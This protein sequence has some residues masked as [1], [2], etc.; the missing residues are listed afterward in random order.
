M[1][2]ISETQTQAQSQAH[3][4]TAPEAPSKVAFLATARRA[5]VK[6]PASERIKD[7]L[8]F[9]KA[10]DDD[11]IR[12]QAT[13][14]MDCGVP[15]CGSACPLGNPLPQIHSLVVGGHFK[16]AS[17]LLHQTNNFP[18][19][20]GRLCPALCE[21]SCS[22]GLIT[23]PMTNR[24]IELAVVE[25]AF[26]SG[27]V[28]PQIATMQS[29]YSVG[30]VGSGPSGLACAQQLA[31]QGHKVTVYERAKVIGGLLAEGI[32]N[33]KLDKR[34]LE[35]R[36]DQLVAEGVVFKPG[37]D[38]NN[39]NSLATIYKH[40]DA[41]CLTTGATVPRDLS[42]PGRQMLGTH[43]A[44][45]FLVQQNRLLAGEKISEAALITA[46]DKVVV[47]LGGGDTGADCLGV[48]LRQGARS[49]IQVEM[50]PEPP[51]ERDPA[52]PWPDWPNI[53]R[54]NSAHEEGGQR[55]F[56][57]GTQS[58]VG[59][60]GRVTGLQ[61]VKLQ[62]HQTVT[63]GRQFSEIKETAYVVPCD[64][65]L[66]AMGFVKT[67][68]DSFSKILGLELTEQGAIKTDG[69]GQTS[70]PRVFAAGDARSG[71]SLICKAIQDGRRVA[72]SIDLMLKQE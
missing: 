30:V 67:E 68:G 13:R 19:F 15:F 5:F 34:I 26:E 64:M 4:D 49:V 23:E 42:A 28:T 61:V 58:F 69:R 22:L 44:M 52:T 12:M 14:C 24:E 27:W 37:N 40:H 71:Q 11:A 29:G 72:K 38:L 1:A 65:V 31:R 33:Y 50:L 59:K 55:L 53:L 70:V 62:W 39:G 43:F 60:N 66:L 25:K 36:L 32:P 41:L 3:V 47:I 54:T 48:A 2:I 9:V 51:K 16:K 57:L 8:E 18:E 20:T 17:E 45:D 46:K 35:R 21:A 10:Q 7:H 56:A 63:M 6:R